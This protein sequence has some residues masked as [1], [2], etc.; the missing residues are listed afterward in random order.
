MSAQ[1]KAMRLCVAVSL[2]NIQGVMVAI[3]CMM[4]AS[5]GRSRSRRWARA[6]WFVD[7]EWAGMF[8]RPAVWRICHLW[9]P[10]LPFVRYQM[11]H[12][13]DN[14]SSAAMPAEHCDTV[15]APNM[16]VASVWRQ[17]TPLH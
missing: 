5:I 16:L 6:T 10:K 17:R 9:A 3:A 1:D 12:A 14:A 8:N 13:L 11:L 4:W 7:W 2:S 15:W